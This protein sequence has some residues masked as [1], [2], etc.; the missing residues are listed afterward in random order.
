M[1]RAFV[2]RYRFDTGDP[3]D[4][5]DFGEPYEPFLNILFETETPRL[6]REDP[7][8]DFFGNALTTEGFVG[9]LLRDIED[10][11]PDNHDGDT[12]FDLM[13]EGPLPNFEVLV[14]DHP[15]NVSQFLDSFR[16]RF[17]EKTHAL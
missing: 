16:S 6:C 7:K 1:T 10:D 3:D 4:P 12:I 11:T 9:V 8:G 5:D 14:R 2:T 15:V 17:P 13:C